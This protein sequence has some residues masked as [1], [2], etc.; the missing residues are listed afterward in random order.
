MSVP[1]LPPGFVEEWTPHAGCTF[2]GSAFATFDRA[3]L[4]A[5]VGWIYSDG[6]R[7]RN[8]ERSGPLSF[9]DLPR[10]SSERR[11]AIA[12]RR[13]V[14]RRKAEAERRRIFTNDERLK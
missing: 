12:E 6:L 7:R 4:V 1:Y 9:D 11:R 5:I 13:E 2:C 10:M 3:E 14:E 8:E